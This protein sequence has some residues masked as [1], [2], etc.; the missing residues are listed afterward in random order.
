MWLMLFVHRL[1][2]LL[3]ALLVAVRPLQARLALVHGAGFLAVRADLEADVA[4]DL[5]L[6]VLRGKIR[7]WF[8]SSSTTAG[9]HFHFLFNY[10]SSST[11]PSQ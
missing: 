1:P 11:F 2:I 5:I 6:L 3:L 8:C 9:A 10:F 7:R 4:L